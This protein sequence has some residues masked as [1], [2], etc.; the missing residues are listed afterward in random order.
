M[1]AGGEINKPQNR[2]LALYFGVCRGWWR[3]FP[4]NDGKGVVGVSSTPPSCVSN[5]GGCRV[6]SLETMGHGLWG[7]SRLFRAR[8]GVKFL[9]LTRNDREGLW[10]CQAPL[11]LAFR[12]REGIST[13]AFWFPWVSPQWQPAETSKNQETWKLGNLCPIS[14]KPLNMVNNRN[15]RNLWKPMETME[16]D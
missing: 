3:A 10:V 15:L 6:R 1:V 9:S 8:E 12:A 2:A 16:T 7:V 11:R 4:W 13:L 14:W 5:E